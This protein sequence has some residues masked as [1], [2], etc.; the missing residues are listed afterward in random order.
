MC[1]IRQFDDT[2]APEGREFMLR[3]PSGAGEIRFFTRFRQT[4]PDAARSALL[5]MVS[6]RLPDDGPVGPW[7]GAKGL[8]GMHEDLTADSKWTELGEIGLEAGALFRI[9]LQTR[10]KDSG[11]FEPDEVKVEFR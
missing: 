8:A 7:S 10:S 9:C 11:A 2:E 6:R 4:R 1:I 3:I 5:L